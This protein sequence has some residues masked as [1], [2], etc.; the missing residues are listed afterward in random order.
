M[1]K[2]I[3]IS[4]LIAAIASSNSVVAVQSREVRQVR[5]DAVASLARNLPRTFITEQALL[6]AL[7]FIDQELDPKTHQELLKIQA[8]ANDLNSQR[9]A[10]LAV[11]GVTVDH[12]AVKYV[13]AQLVLVEKRLDDLLYNGGFFHWKTMLGLGVGAVAGAALYTGHAPVVGKQVKLTSIVV[14]LAVAVVLELAIRG[15][16]AVLAGN[17]ASL[18]KFISGVAT[19]F[20]RAV[21]G[22]AGYV[23]LMVAKV[24]GWLRNFGKKLDKAMNNRLVTLGIGGACGLGV[25]ALFY[26]ANKQTA[27]A[28]VGA[29]A[30]EAPSAA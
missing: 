5:S 24:E 7:N 26:V 25:A 22:D 16:R 6:D 21:F 15:R 3:A 13:D 11:P 28:P 20:F 17:F 14:G 8:E 27:G 10:F 4:A 9:E 30:A 23:D 12:P 19:K 1:K 18:A 29:S 2:I